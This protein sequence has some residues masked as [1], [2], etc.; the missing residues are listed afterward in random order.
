[1]SALPSLV[2]VT[3]WLATVRDLRA[4]PEQQ[5]AAVSNLLV[6]YARASARARGLDESDAVLE[7]LEQVRA[8]RGEDAAY[9]AAQSADVDLDRLREEDSS[10]RE[11]REREAAFE[12][13]LQWDEP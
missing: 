3:S 4:A 1:M 6:A 2:M 9:A 8:T 12:S 7:A 5:A 13:T 10:E 11:Y